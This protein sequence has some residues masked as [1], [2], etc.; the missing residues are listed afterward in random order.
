MLQVS[1]GRKW[2]LSSAN[3]CYWVF[4]IWPYCHHCFLANFGRSRFAVFRHYV[5]SHL[6]WITYLLLIAYMDVT[7]TAE[8]LV[9]FVCGTECA[10][11]LFAVLL[12]AEGT[13]EFLAAHNYF[14]LEMHR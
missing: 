13:V 6:S 10:G 12:T 3:E 1:A 4:C 2:I 8:L 5:N 11:V 14:S 7:S 9:T